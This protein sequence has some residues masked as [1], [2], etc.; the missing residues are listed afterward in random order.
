MSRVLT[1]N[2][3]IIP[4]AKARAKKITTIHPKKTIILGWRMDGSI[5]PRVMKNAPVAMKIIVMIQLVRLVVTHI[6]LQQTA[7]VIMT[8]GQIITMALQF[9]STSLLPASQ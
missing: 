9:P 2:V 5:L 4:A 7:A 1:R 6:L 3:V 8:N